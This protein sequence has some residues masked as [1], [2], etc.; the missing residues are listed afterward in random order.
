MVEKKTFGQIIRERRQE[1]SISQKELASKIKKED[2]MQISPQYENDIEFDRRDPPSEDMIRQY[3]K[4]LDLH[5]EAL[6]LAAGRVPEEIRNIAARS[7][8]RAQQ[9]FQAFRK[10]PQED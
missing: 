1:L 4:A 2:G 10:K 3:A 6:I 8:E 7:P 9:V 5:A